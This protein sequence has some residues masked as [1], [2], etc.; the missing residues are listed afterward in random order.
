[1]TYRAEYY[2]LY[3]NFIYGIRQNEMVYESILTTSYSAI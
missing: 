2:V 1:M 3:D